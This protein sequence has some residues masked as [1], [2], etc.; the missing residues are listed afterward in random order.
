MILGCAFPRHPSNR[1][2]SHSLMWVIHW[3][4]SIS[5]PDGPESSDAF[6][7]GISD[8]ME[9]STVNYGNVTDSRRSSW[10]LSLLTWVTRQAKPFFHMCVAVI[11]S[12]FKSWLWIKAFV[13]SL[14]IWKVRLILSFCF[15]T[16]IFSDQSLTC[17]FLTNSLWH[18]H[19]VSF[20]LQMILTSVQFWVIQQAGVYISM[21][22]SPSYVGQ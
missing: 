13:F 7:S 8:L 10:E 17:C 5:F 9:D 21:Y 11:V 19:S 12:C 1:T 22:T 2:S 6:T 18:F 4:Y 3:Q 15:Y 20:R 16:F 14:L